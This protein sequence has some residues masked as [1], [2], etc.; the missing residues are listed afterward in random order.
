MKLENTSRWQFLVLFII[1]ISLLIYPAAGCKTPSPAS[2]ASPQPVP[3][4][5]QDPTTIT[6]S[7]AP[8][9]PYINDRWEYTVYFPRDWFIEN[10]MSSDDRGIL[11]FHAP[12]PY[13]ATLNIEV[14]DIERMGLEPDIEILAQ[15]CLED[16]RHIWGEIVLQENNSLNNSWDWY[17]AFDGVLWNL[18]CHVKVYLKLTED[19][20]YTSTLR[21]IKDEFDDA[22][23]SNLELIPEAFEFHS[24]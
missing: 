20:L 17:Y 16:T 22:Y 24:A 5:P 18:D 9:V 10:N 21:V 11:D 13:H 7:T 2:Q 8:L 3:S 19:F 4:I 15:Q 1:I 14:A 6:P 23:L 12:H